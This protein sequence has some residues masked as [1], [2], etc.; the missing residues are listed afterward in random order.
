MDCGKQIATVFYF[1]FPKYEIEICMYFQNQHYAQ[2][3]G[4]IYQHSILRPLPAHAVVPK[5]FFFIKIC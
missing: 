1:H 4:K 2:I 3:T 5:G